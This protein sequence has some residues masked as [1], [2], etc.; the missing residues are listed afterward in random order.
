MKK[1]LPKIYILLTCALL[2]FNAC[3]D[4][5]N[6][7]AA[8]GGGG[9]TPYNDTYKLNLRDTGPAGG[10]IFYINPNADKDGWKYLEAAPV[11]AEAVNKLWSSSTGSVG[12]TNGAIGNGKSSTAKIV[13][14]L[15]GK[16]E[17]DRAAQICDGSTFGSFTDWFLP[18]SSEL[19]TMYQV[20]KQNGVGDF[21]GTYWSSSELNDVQAMRRNFDDGTQGNVNKNTSHKVRPV[22]CF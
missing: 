5:T 2:V 21:S 6:E 22:R 16:S 9:T 1:A 7:Q 12:V 20:L 17:S 4:D 13:A 14:W 10:L 3:S 18:S 8:G 11:G 15:N 19:T